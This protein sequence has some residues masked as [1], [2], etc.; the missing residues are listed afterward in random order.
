LAVTRILAYELL[1]DPALQ[2]PCAIVLYNILDSDKDSYFLKIVE[3]IDYEA[4]L[5]SCQEE[6]SG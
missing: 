2:Q 4:L 6:R 1:L 5:D 3:S